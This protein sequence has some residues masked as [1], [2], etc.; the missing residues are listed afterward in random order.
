MIDAEKLVEFLAFRKITANQYLLCHL[1][2]L[3]KH[4]LLKKYVADKNL[5][6]EA[7]KKR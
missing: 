1:L 3:G 5:Q 7:Q 6:F 2:Y 4:E